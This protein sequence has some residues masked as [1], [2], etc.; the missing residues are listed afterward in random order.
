[1]E[2]KDFFSG[3]E[4]LESL[5]STITGAPVGGGP[6]DSIDG[7]K[8]EPIVDPSTITGNTN[9]DS[10]NQDPDGDEPGTDNEPNNEP[11]DSQDPNQ[12]PNNDQDGGQEPANDPAQEPTQEPQDVS[13]LGDAEPEMAQ[14]VQEKLY[15][16]F[17]IDINDDTQAFESFDDITEFVLNAIDANSIPEFANEKVA[18]IDKYVRDGGKLEEFMGAVH[19]GV[20]I[21]TP[22]MENENYLKSVVMEDL[23]NQGMTEARAKRRVERMEDSG[24]LVEEAEDALESIKDYRSLQ[25]DKL[26]KDQEKAR[27]DREQANMRYIHS[28]QEQLKNTDEIMGVKL[29]EKEKKDVYNYI[30]QPDKDGN[31]EFQKA[32][33]AS[34]ENV[35][36][37]AH[38]LKNG[39]KI[40][41]VIEK[42]ATSNAAK[43]LKTKL[44]NNKK[45]GKDQSTSQSTSSDTWGLLS[46]QLRK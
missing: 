9:D 6:G 21:D 32:L 43:K 18:A 19:R 39:G 5:T 42:K 12:D 7:D 38:L 26:L 41:K 2:G 34:V 8:G 24:I 31:T 14:Y 4:A 22:D 33:S 25:A 29:S 10:I 1:M 35:I 16:R 17:G 13:G 20:D 15:E 45:R 11:G 40:N 36:T 30:F 44:S 3:F 23:L 37:V 46:R 27:A 28:V